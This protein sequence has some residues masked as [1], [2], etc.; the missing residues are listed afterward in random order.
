M[1]IL[2]QI[3]RA[4]DD[5]PRLVRELALIAQRDLATIQRDLAD[6]ARWMVEAGRGQADE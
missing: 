6:I 2:D 3:A 1:R 4:A 5:N